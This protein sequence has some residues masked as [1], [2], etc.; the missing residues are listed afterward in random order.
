MLQ[1]EALARL[2][3]SSRAHS[4]TTPSNPCFFG[5]VLREFSTTLAFRTGSPDCSLSTFRSYARLPTCTR[6]LQQQCF[7]GAFKGALAEFLNRAH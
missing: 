6:Q 5:L 3:C 1:L 7:K 4:P 2:R